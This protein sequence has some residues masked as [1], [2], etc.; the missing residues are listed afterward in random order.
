MLDGQ[1]PVHALEAQ[2][3]LAIQEVGDVGLL[4]SCLL[5]QAEAGQLPFID[6]PPKSF[7]E[8]VL[9]HSEFHSWEYSMGAYSNTLTKKI[10]TG[11]I[12][13]TNLDSDIW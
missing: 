10:S 8:V 13:I 6:A 7:A 2:A 4:E 12:G 1:Y 3:A 11:Y 5:G 9:Q